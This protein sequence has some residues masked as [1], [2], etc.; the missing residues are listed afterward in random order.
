MPANIGCALL[1]C[2]VLKHVP[3]GVKAA[4]VGLGGAAGV[5]LGLIMTTEYALERMERLGPDYSL[6]RNAML[7]VE[8][9]RIQRQAGGNDESA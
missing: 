3:L 7:E 5:M 1:A 8:E 4:A 2:A 9:N 6:G